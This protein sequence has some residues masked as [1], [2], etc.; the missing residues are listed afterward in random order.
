MSPS[1][2]I[3]TQLPTTHLTFFN[4]GRCSASMSEW[5]GTVSLNTIGVSSLSL[6]KLWR[7]AKEINQELIAM[8]KPNCV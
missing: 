8:K 3:T 5:A 7:L 4:E 2:S 6:P 1:S